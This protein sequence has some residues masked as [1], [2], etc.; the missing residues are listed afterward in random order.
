MRMRDIMN[1]LE[2]DLIDF[3][4][5]RQERLAMAVQKAEDDLE[6]G[7]SDYVEFIV[8]SAEGKI[9]A[10]TLPFS[11]RTSTGFVAENPNR[12]AAIRCAL[13]DEGIRYTERPFIDDGFGDDDGHADDDDL[14]SED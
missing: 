13:E 10:E 11:M 14:G 8:P 4:A 7:G 12:I 9:F 1:V 5:K 6:L 3:N 2:A